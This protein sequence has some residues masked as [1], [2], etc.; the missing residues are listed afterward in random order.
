MVKEI[1]M[2]LELLSMADFEIPMQ[3]KGLR[4]SGS[5]GMK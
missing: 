3:W 2:V 1:A 5:K 4:I